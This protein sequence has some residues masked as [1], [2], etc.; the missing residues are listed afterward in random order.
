MGEIFGGDFFG[1]MFWEDFLEGFFGED[2]W[3]EFFVYIRI[4]FFVKIL[5]FARFGL[6]GE[7]RRRSARI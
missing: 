1:R 2:F 7:G 5:I 4:D 6:N 3:E